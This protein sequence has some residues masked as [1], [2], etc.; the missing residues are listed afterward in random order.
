M[1][2]QSLPSTLEGLPLPV[3]RPSGP[4]SSVADEP[5]KEGSFRKTLSTSLSENSSRPDAKGIEGDRQERRPA[6]TNNAPRNADATPR[7]ERPETK[8][9]QPQSEKAE[10]P[11][12]P[13]AQPRKKASEGEPPA[14]LVEVLVAIET[15][16]GNAGAISEI[17][18]TVANEESALKQ[19]N[20]EI[21]ESLVATGEST[22][23]SGFATALTT[24][25]SASTA[26]QNPLV[27]PAGGVA[28][29]PL[30]ESAVTSPT[31]NEQIP[32]SIPNETGSVT[33]TATADPTTNLSGSHEGAQQ[34]SAGSVINEAGPSSPDSKLSEEKGPA[35]NVAAVTVNTDEENAEAGQAQAQTT[36]AEK[37]ESFQVEADVAQPK[38]DVSPAVVEQNS[39][40]I[41]TNQKQQSDNTPEVSVDSTSDAPGFTA[42]SE[43]PGLNPRSEN[44]TSQQSTDDGAES[45]NSQEQGDGPKQDL[46][47]T[48]ATSLNVVAGP[49]TTSTEAE[50]VSSSSTADSTQTIASP[51]T[52]PTQFDATG[53]NGNETTPVRETVD[54]NHPNFME[55]VAQAVQ[56]SSANRNQVTLRLTPP[57]LGALQIDVIVEKGTLT[58]RME[59]QNPAAQ[60][61]LTESL[62]QLKEALSQN[63]ATLE[64]IE[65]FLA[66][67]A[68]DDRGANAGQGFTHENGQ[69]DQRGEEFLTA[70]SER[71]VAEAEQDAHEQTPAV[72]GVST[73]ASGRKELDVHI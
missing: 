26:E 31:A 35:T 42:Q 29:Q 18:E 12:T 13:E 46:E 28:N 50:D 65:V 36:S 4:K 37:T 48:T 1:P 73:N 43:E 11:E 67:N 66:D 53:L 61:V 38:K 72:L 51:V 30:P 59:V 64:R 14:E 70:Q 45:D 21:N 2:T 17:Q 9:S 54:V 19:L 20:G 7:A 16:T 57:E 33:D 5:S 10:A 34:L 71:E 58:A 25:Q 49:A 47:Q 60:R 3:V 68:T 23:P 44:S 40:Q 52:G 27:V 15:R 24:G 41:N 69:G 8:Q 55:R 32:E 39:A 22:P 6:E 62:P 56:T 63:S